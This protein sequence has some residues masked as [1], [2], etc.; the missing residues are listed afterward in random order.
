MPLIP[1]LR[2]QRQSDICEFKTSLVYR[3]SSKTARTVRMV[4]HR[5]S[6]S[7]NKNKQTNKNP[8]YSLSL[9]IRETQ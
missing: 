8:I 5:N 4:M 7:I 3:E 2:R 9:I 1:A 6:A